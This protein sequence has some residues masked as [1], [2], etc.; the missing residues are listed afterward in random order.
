MLSVS[1]LVAA[2][3]IYVIKNQVLVNIIELTSAIFGF[4]YIFS[5]SVKQK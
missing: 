2:I 1:V 4:I 5:E 3:I